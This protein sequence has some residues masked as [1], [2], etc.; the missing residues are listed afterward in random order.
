MLDNRSD[1]RNEMWNHCAPK[2]SEEFHQRFEQTLEDLNARETAKRKRPMKFKV[3]LAAA[4]LCVLASGTVLAAEWFGWN[5]QILN[6]FQP[7]QKQQEQLPETGAI[8]NVEQVSTV[9]DVPVTLKQVIHDNYNLYLLC[10]ITLPENISIDETQRENLVFDGF[11]VLID[12]KDPSEIVPN[13]S[14]SGG[15]SFMESDD[16]TVSNT[17]YYEISYLFGAPI[18]WNGRTLS[19]SLGDLQTSY[20]KAALPEE[21]DT[22]ASGPWTFDYSMDDSSDLTWTIEVNN[23][24]DFGGYDILINSIEISPLSYV[25]H[26]DYGT[27]MKVEEDERNT[28]E[29][30]GDDPG[31]EL[32][33]RLAI[34]KIVYKD[35]TEIAY[36]D[37][38]FTDG[39][40]YG[41]N[42]DQSE[43]LVREAFVRIID[44]DQIQSIYLMQ[45]DVEITL[46]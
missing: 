30:N 43:Y 8:Q 10:E 16:D 3:L 24:Y 40:V 20:K 31:I 22:L 35:G 1:N 4:A 38:M 11:S 46:Q 28:F 33:D 32:G 17:L 6:K 26:A 37:D 45:G 21:C 41:P 25:V 34:R 29:Y 12:G 42:E 14:Y 19:L 15:G 9:N 39:G 23:T 5:T 7:S 36:P 2:V 13:A 27:A 18:D 44:V